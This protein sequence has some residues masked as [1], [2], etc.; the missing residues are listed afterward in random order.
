MGCS[1]YI[2]I[3]GTVTVHVGQSCGKMKSNLLFQIA[4]DKNVL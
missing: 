2:S 3:C 1:S 4:I